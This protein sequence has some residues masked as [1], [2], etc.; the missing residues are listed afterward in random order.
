M[1]SKQTLTTTGKVRESLARAMDLCA[2][3]ELAVNDGKN[4]IGLAN[5]ITNSIA[6]EI[7]H[8]NMQVSLGRNIKDL[9]DMNIGGS[10]D[11]NE[12]SE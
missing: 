4:L 5:Q 1:K 2:K 11:E 3:G 10:S 7:K 6:V 8:Q 12:G 9:G